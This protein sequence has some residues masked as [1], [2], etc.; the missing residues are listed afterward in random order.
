MQFSQHIIF[1]GRANND[2]SEKPTTNQLNTSLVGCSIWVTS[3]FDNFVSISILI[4]HFLS[5]K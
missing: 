5:S 2:E 3:S 4:N 1:I